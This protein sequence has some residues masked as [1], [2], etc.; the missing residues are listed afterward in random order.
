MILVDM[1]QMT[2]AN[3]M[4]ESKGKPSYNEDLIRHMII[5]NLRLLKNK[6]SNEYGN[7]VL[8]YDSPLSWRKLKYSFYKQ[9]RKKT[10]DESDFD[11][12]KLYLF[13]NTMK[14]DLRSNFPYKVMDCEGCEADD[15]I[16]VLCKNYKEKTVI[17]SGDE[18]FFQ[19][20]KYDYVFQYSGYHKK[21]V[22]CDNPKEYLFEH[23][24][25]G[26]ASDGIPNILSKEDIF[27]TGGRQTRISTKKLD[28][29]KSLCNLSGYDQIS[30]DASIIA[31]ISR[32]RELIDFD[33]IPEKYQDSIL[34][35]YNN[36]VPA[37]KNNLVPYFM[38]KGLKNLMEN[39]TEF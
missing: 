21:L 36:I 11:W 30:T 29:W 27:I 3:I 17:I 26:D 9:N 15:I 31:N 5:N 6:F 35:R 24:I 34:N 1:N 10:R 8:C 25:R 38:E 32:N 28:E 7:I 18:D 13:L 33:Y 14:E 2:I 19:L 37:S 4:S 39:I 20:Q 23:V 16:A 22:K 12:K